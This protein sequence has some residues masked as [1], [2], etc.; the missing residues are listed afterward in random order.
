M[1]SAEAAPVAC[2]VRGVGVEDTV[3]W[4]EVITWRKHLYTS[5]L[6]QRG[7]GEL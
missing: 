5:L 6:G 4:V 3:E 2:V 7:W 1:V